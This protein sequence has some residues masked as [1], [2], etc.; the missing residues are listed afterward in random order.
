MLY[1]LTVAGIGT[2]S[3]FTVLTA[4]QNRDLWIQL[5]SAPN[6]AISKLK[7]LPKTSPLRDLIVRIINPFVQQEMG[8]GLDTNGIVIVEPGPNG[9]RLGFRAGDII[10]E[11]NGVTIIS[12]EQID[13]LV[14]SSSRSGQ[15]IISRNGQRLIIRY[16]L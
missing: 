9:S 3:K 15:F 10:E 11:I 8:L 16:R 5:S 4:G 7:R 12:A 14:G 1:R 2:Q 13:E 6:D